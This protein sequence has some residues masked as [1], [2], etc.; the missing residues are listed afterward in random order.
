MER[1]CRCHSRFRCVRPS[2]IT[3]S[4]S[5]WPPATNWWTRCW[6][7]WRAT[8][9]TW[10]IATSSSEL[11][12]AFPA[13]AT[14]SLMSSPEIGRTV[15]HLIDSAAFQEWQSGQGGGDIASVRAGRRQE[16]F[17][18][19]VASNTREG[20]VGLSHSSRHPALA[21]MGSTVVLPV[22]AGVA[23]PAMAKPNHRAQRISCVNNLKQIGLAELTFTPPNMAICCQGFRVDAERTAITTRPDLSWS[24]TQRR[25]FKLGDFQFRRCHLR[26]SRAGGR[27]LRSA[28][29]LRPVPH[30]QPNVCLIDGSVHSLV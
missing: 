17:A 12:R 5:S 6:R 16:S 11:P 4:I 26:N 27:H 14:G 10:R 9:T 28:E 25:R 15:S 19:S 21:F 8:R 3:A 22:V 2:P 1:E 13:R 7:R 24:Q 23:L 18:F 29:G 20:W 30:S